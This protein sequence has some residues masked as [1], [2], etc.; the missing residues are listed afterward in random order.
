MDELIVEDLQNE[1]AAL[2]VTNETLSTENTELK[3][4]NEVLT[5]ENAALKEKVPEL[6]GEIAD[7]TK[8]A[9]PFITIK[10]QK[11]FRIHATR[12]GV[13]KQEAKDMLTKL[14]NRQGLKDSQLVEVNS[15]KF[16]A[17]IIR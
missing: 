3:A 15:G 14:K 17:Y 1:N 11:Y 4:N 16:A 2:K 9:D 5:K 13:P 7:T 10:G 6:K 12:Y 8:E